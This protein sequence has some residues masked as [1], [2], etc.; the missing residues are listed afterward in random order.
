MRKNWL[1]LILATILV[2]IQFDATAQQQQKDKYRSKANDPVA[3]LPYYKKLRWADNLF[4]EGSY[5]NAIE[6]YLQLKQEQERNPYLAYQL[7]ESY[8]MTRDYKPSAIYY[9]QAYSMAPKLYPEAIFKQGIML[10]MQGDYEGAINAFNNFIQDNPKTFKKL[11]KRAQ[12]E[13]E[14]ANMALN[15]LKDPIP[16]T[17]VNAG[18]NVNSAY[19]ELAPYPL[20]DTALLFATMR[21]NNPVEVSKRNREDYMSRFMV[22]HKQPHVAQVDSF[23]WPLPFNDGDFN[24]PKVHIGNGVYSPGGDRFYYTKCTEEDSMQ[25]MCKIYVSKFEGSRWTEGQLLGEGINEDG[26]N[27]QPFVAMV[28]KKEV[29]FFSSNR[30]LQSR[31]GYDIW[32]SV[33]DPRNNTYRRPQNAG[34][35]I[36]TEMDEVTPYYDDRVGKL[37]FASNGWVTMGGFDIFSADGGPSRYTNLTNLGYPINTSADE[38]YFIKDPSGKPDAYVVSNRIGSIALK[39]P[40]CCD[41]IWRIQ[42]EPKLMVLGKVIDRKTQKLMDE[43]V[44]K[45]ADQQGDMK[46]YNSTNG[47]F[48]FNMARGKSYVITGDKQG[49]ASTRASIN[50]M[51]VQRTDPDDTVM[52][53]IYMDEITNEYR[54]RV[55]NVFY[56]F[57]KATLRPESI[58][59]LDSLVN[60]MKDNPSLNVE[61]YSFADAKGSD[62]YNRNLSIRRAE[63]VMKYLDNAGIDRSRMITKGFGESMPVASNEVNGKDNP[64]GRQL[65]RRTE[66]RIVTDVPTRRVLYN[67]AKPGSMDDQAKNLQVDENMN[68]DDT[69]PDAE[70]NIGAPGSRVNQNN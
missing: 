2:T 49:Y 23:Q 31:G 12:R 29:L 5:F 42:Y 3:K 22:S 63:S 68:E 13:I 41:D 27:T 39:N 54:F 9:G 61:I 40:T 60:F 25:V 53:T 59:S 47:N 58:A 7:A 57:D 44:V 21:Q 67:S 8:W 65:N 26:S 11:K 19:T 62:N 33:I 16:V 52:V 48:A 28:G 18:P 10:K 30:T 32:Y 50:T 14:G 66:F 55:S 70:G 1:L 43:V 38:L 34:K 69:T 4:R 56:D 15:S 17:V 37:Y 20:G 36:N 35:Q 24:S 51:D 46:T 6:Y 64:V 45:M